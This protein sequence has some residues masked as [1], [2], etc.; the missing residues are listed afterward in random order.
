VQPHLRL[1]GFAHSV[2]NQVI[3][4]GFLRIGSADV[5]S[6][7]AQL[8]RSA[9]GN[10]LFVWGNVRL[11]LWIRRNVP[12]GNNLRCHGVRCFTGKTDLYFPNS[13]GSAPGFNNERLAD[14]RRP[15]DVGM[16]CDDESDF[17]ECLGDSYLFVEG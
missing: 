4:C 3:Q 2:G 14:L 9:G 13:L 8:F 5:E 1:A 16:A 7:F 6:G 12:H 10:G 15:C 11:D 17:G